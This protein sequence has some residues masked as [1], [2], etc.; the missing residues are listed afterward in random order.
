M[1]II[2]VTPFVMKNA[3]ISFG[4]DDF[5]KA[6]SSAV[7]TPSGG[8]TPFKGLKTDAVYTFPQSV[9]WTLDLTFAQDWSIAGSLSKYLW[10][11][12][13]QNVACT[14]NVDDKAG[15][16]GETSWALTV[17]ITPGAVGGPVD[18]VAVATV[19]LGVIGAP[20]PTLTP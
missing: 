3:V 2:A 17:S 5:A 19:S 4:T 20:V 15:T 14:I 1:A 12:Q 6:V 16:T 18:S 13:G 11:N 10:T 7:L 8:M 9:T